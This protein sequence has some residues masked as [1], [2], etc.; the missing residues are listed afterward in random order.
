MSGPMT[1][2]RPIDTLRRVA[3]T[4][5][6]GAAGAS[7]AWAIGVPAPFLTGPAALVTLL[8]LLG[9]RTEIPFL[10][11]DL[12]FVLIGIG[13]GAGI[14]PEVVESLPR[15]P[16]PLAA[17]AL[18][19]LVI[20]FAGGGALEFLFG[21]DRNTARLSAVPGHLSF[22]LSLSVEV[23]SD[24][25]VIS[26]IQSLRVLLLTLA[27]PPVVALVTGADLTMT[28]FQPEIM[29]TVALVALLVLGG[30]I[31]V[32]FKRLHVPAALLLGGMAVSGVSHGAGWITGAPPAWVTIPTFTI[33]GGLIGT[34]FSGVPLTLI[35]R[36]AT[37]S[38]ALTA[39]AVGVTVGAAAAV[40]ALTGLPVTDLL[41]AFAPGGLETMAAL[42]IMLGADPAFTALHHIYRLVLLSFLTPMIVTTSRKPSDDG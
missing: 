3:V 9:V 40:H 19:L 26:V 6:A 37:A 27:V 33:M 13:M 12:C 29:S 23:A 11:R 14:T 39:L 35:G 5:G 34:R 4:L 30:G 24:V 20:I 7:L 16:V 42:A 15:W 32:F 31:G 25:R 22:V 38:A 1:D 21:F 28:G 2:A 17:L 8:S 36:A 18:G 10:I 41:I